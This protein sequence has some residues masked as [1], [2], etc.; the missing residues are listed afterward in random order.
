MAILYPNVTDSHTEREMALGHQRHLFS[1]TFDQVGQDFQGLNKI[2]IDH[3][4]LNYN[5][6]VIGDNTSKIIEVSKELSR[7]IK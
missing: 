5:R 6:S 4:I 3:M 1:G 7:F 2:G